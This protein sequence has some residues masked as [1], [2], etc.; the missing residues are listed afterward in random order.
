MKYKILALM[1]FAFISSS[2]N[3][4]K[5]FFVSVE[6]GKIQLKQKQEEQVID[7]SYWTVKGI[8]ISGKYLTFKGVSSW[9]DSSCASINFGQHTYLG[10]NKYKYKSINPELV[11]SS[12][13]YS[14][15]VL[16]KPEFLMPTSGKYYFELRLSYQW[17]NIMY[18]SN[19]DGSSPTFSMRYGNYDDTYYNNFIYEKG[20]N[21]SKS[22]FNSGDIWQIWV[23]IDAGNILI[24]KLNL[25]ES[26]SYNNPIIN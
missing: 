20:V 14:G 7:P 10:D 1:F 9:T 22:R 18:L 19:L 6:V 11:N 13:C 16:R 23:D 3:A 21:W 12:G 4:G 8:D 2:A 5:D 25:N 15:E 26:S 17:A 24:N